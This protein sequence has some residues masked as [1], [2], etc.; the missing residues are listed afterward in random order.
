MH[1]ARLS[2]K[3]FKAFAELEIQL[4]S[5]PSLVVLCG[6]NG[7]GKS[8]ISDAISHWR[9]RD[10]WGWGNDPAFFRRGG[11]RA[12]VENGTV[13]IDLCTGSRRDW[14]AGYLTSPQ[15]SSAP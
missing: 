3:D 14:S 13:E 6:E 1:I 4:T 2:M 10:Y 8:S 5:Q 12:G 15:E 11:D 9:N 7:S